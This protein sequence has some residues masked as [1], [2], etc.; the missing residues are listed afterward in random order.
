MARPPS[1][2]APPARVGPGAALRARKRAPP[3]GGDVAVWSSDDCEVEDG[4]ARRVRS[5]RARPPLNAP[6]LSIHLTSTGEARRVNKRWGTEEVDTL[7]HLVAVHGAGKWK[8]IR[9]AGGPA[10]AARTQVDLKDK[11][12]NLNRAREVAATGAPPARE[13][14]QM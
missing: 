6:P 4:E 3:S 8:Q 11:W 13:I 2:P 1:R 5:R 10:F 12:R 14:I 9:D 7:I